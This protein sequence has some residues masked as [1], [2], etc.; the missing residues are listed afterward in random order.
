[1]RTWNHYTTIGICNSNSIRITNKASNILSSCPI[2]PIIKIN[3]IIVICMNWATG[4]TDG[5][6]PRQKRQIYANYWHKDMLTFE[7]LLEG[8]GKGLGRFR[9]GSRKG[10]VWLKHLSL[11]MI[12]FAS[13]LV[14][15]CR[16]SCIC[17]TRNTK[18]S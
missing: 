9:K 14:L 5:E 3:G 11:L 6:N 12:K 7:Q 2:W 16:Y 15:L 1:M 4:N 10:I 13:E 17:R 8:S 18:C